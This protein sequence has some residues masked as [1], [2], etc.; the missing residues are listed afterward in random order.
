MGVSSLRMTGSIDIGIGQSAPEIRRGASA[1]HATAGHDSGNVHRLVERSLATA[2]AVGVKHIH[3]WG[4]FHNSRL[5]LHVLAR[6]A[7]P[8]DPDAILHVRENKSRLE[9][10]A[11]NLEATCALAAS[12][13]LKARTSDERAAALDLFDLA[14]RRLGGRMPVEYHDLHVT[15]A[16]LNGDAKRVKSLIKSYSGVSERLKGALHCQ[17]AHPRNGGSA[18]AFVERLKAFAHW[19]E[20]SEPASGATL[21]IDR[22][23]TEPVPAVEDGPLISVVMTCFEPDAMLLTAVRSVVAQS[24]QHWELL[25]VDDGSGPA[26]EDVLLEAA[27]LDPR[28]KLLI[29]PENAGTYQARNRAMAVAEGEFIT[30]LDSDDWAHPRRLEAQVQPL[31]DRPKLVMVESLSI[32]VREDLSLMIDPQVAVVAARSTPIMIRAGA[33]LRHV[34]FYDEV[35][36]SADSE[37]RLRIK[38]AFGKR[39][40]ARLATLPLTLVRHAET[41]LSAGEVSRHWMSASRFAYHSGFTQWHRRIAKGQTPPFLAAHA[42]P[43]P[44][45]IS[46]D[47]TRAKVHAIDYDAIYAADWSRTDERRKSMLEDAARRAGQGD[48]VGLVHCPDWIGVDGTRSLVHRFVLGSAAEHGL[49]F[50]DLDE[51]H[52]ASVVVP[53]EAYAELLRFEHPGLADDRVRVQPFASEAAAPLPPAAKRRRGKGAPRRAL[54]RRDALLAGAGLCS[55][56]AACVFAATA[57]P[58]SLPWVAT[59]S[60]AIWA[61]SVL[62]LIALRRAL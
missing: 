55:A 44:F 1:A 23:R 39:A 48:A 4:Q 62:A 47:I 33:V 51:R 11:L 54:R 19:P 17:E 60:L 46:R 24:W 7:H 50:I 31:L 12:I 27:S 41:T 26:Y 20:L 6:L 57:E 13:G 36:R 14:H 58:A 35:R 9:K 53:T 59:G 30:G 5:S 29:Q 18:D 10:A 2:K 3:E 16:Y 34:G 61:G 21:S 43:R 22:L 40:S 38:T 52:T 45:A 15:V 32:A 28:V 42:S 8:D 56:A 37:Y 49:D 25:L